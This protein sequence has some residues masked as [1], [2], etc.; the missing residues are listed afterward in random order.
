MDRGLTEMKTATS[1]KDD[2]STRIPRGAV[3]LNASRF[4]PAGDGEASG[5]GWSRRL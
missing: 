2:P 1:I 4:A 5:G 3:L